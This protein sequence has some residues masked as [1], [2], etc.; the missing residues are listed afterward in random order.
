MTINNP[1]SRLHNLEGSLSAKEAFLLWLKKAPKFRLG[2]DY[3]AYLL[4]QPP[5]A[6]PLKRLCDEFE[7]SCR[8]AMEG[9]S[10]W[11]LE[12]A[13][14]QGKR[15]RAFLFF[16]YERVNTHL[17]SVAFGYLDEV[18]K[19]KD[20]LWDILIRN[21]LLSEIRRV[22]SFG[23]EKTAYPLDRRTASAVEAAMR[24][25]V[26]PRPQISFMTTQWVCDHFIRQGK[27]RLP[28]S[29]PLLFLAVC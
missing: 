16:L 21:R 22:R 24:H 14:V 1:H 7:E 11:E 2:P 8:R 9:E 4:E 25:Y 6:H 26:A 28:R 29:F 15:D 27:R 5:W 17:A 10:H 3:T 18:E 12:R 23:I 20:R 13:I 19:L